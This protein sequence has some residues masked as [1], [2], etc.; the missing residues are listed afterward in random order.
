MAQDEQ[1]SQANATNRRDCGERLS[2]VTAGAGA[3]ATTG[4][5]ASGPSSLKWA[6]SCA[7]SAA[8]VAASWCVAPRSTV[9]LRSLRTRSIALSLV[10]TAIVDL[11]RDAVVTRAG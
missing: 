1:A 6:L 11:A 5:G 4:S 10:T 7:A 8:A 2:A 9:T 3:G